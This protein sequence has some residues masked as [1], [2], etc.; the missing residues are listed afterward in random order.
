VTVYRLGDALVLAIL[1][2]MGV[3]EGAGLVAGRRVDRARFSI[4]LG[5]CR[6]RVSIHDR[7]SSGCIPDRCV[8]SDDFFLS[9][10]NQSICVLELF[11]IWGDPCGLLRRLLSAH[12]WW[13][14]VMESSDGLE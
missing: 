4:P 14:P 7:R 9:G 1:F 13:Y 2:F 11:L 12:L 6:W 5:V 10:S 3:V 8:S